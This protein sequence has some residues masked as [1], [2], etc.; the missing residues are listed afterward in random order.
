MIFLT[1]NRFRQLTFLLV[2][3]MFICTPLANAQN[4]TRPPQ[5]V[6]VQGDWKET[7][8]EAIIDAKIKAFKLLIEVE[9]LT[10]KCK[11]LSTKR[12]SGVFAIKLEMTCE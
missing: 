4:S 10:Y 9:G 7:R 11:I 2:L 6:I 12:K 3:G 8:E 1:K 5:T